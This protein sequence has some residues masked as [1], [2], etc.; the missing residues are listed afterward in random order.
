MRSYV[1]AKGNARKWPTILSTWTAVRPTTNSSH[2]FRNRRTLRAAE[3]S[4]T[5][6]LTGYTYV[7]GWVNKPSSWADLHHGLGEQTFI[8]THRSFRSCR[9]SDRSNN[10][11]GVIQQTNKNI[12]TSEWNRTAHRFGRHIIGAHV[13]GARTLM[14]QT[15]SAAEFKTGDVDDSQ[16]ETARDRNFR[17]QPNINVC[18]TPRMHRRIQTFY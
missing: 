17:S 18:S 16:A 1:R 5:T 4:L 2:K 14:T 6:L 7:V 11:Q 13:I 3:V 9:G 15:Q 8:G 12:I 10:A